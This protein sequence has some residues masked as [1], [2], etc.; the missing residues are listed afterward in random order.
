MLCIGIESTAHTLGVGIFDG[1]RMLANEKDMYRPKKGG[2]HPRM[3]ADHHAEVFGEVL[4]RAIAK[5][6]VEPKE[7]DLVA[8]ARGPGLGPCLKVGLAGAM[9]LAS[10]LGVKLVPVNHCSAHVEIGALYCK[11]K[12]PLVLY[13][14]G[15]NTQIVTREQKNRTRG[16]HAMGETLD[17]GVGNLIDVFARSL[18]GEFAHGSVVEKLALGGKYLPMPY[19]VKGMNMTFS[20]LLTDATKQLGGH[21]RKDVCFSLQETAFSMLTEATERALTLTRKKE[22]LACGGVAQNKRLCEML[23]LMAR[24]HGARFATSPAEFNADNGAMIAYTGLLAR[25][26]AMDWRRTDVNAKWRLDEAVI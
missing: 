16:Y 8:Y 19:T 13:V 9:A 21:D 17:I 10:R 1:K 23:K 26:H 22:V 20:G 3:A 11:M 6:R 7:I 2:I 24:E 18:D 4:R 15:G 5:A 12:D 25:R 14:S